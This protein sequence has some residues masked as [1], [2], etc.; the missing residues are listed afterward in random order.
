MAK[1]LT[2]FAKL[3]Y[4]CDIYHFLWE[5]TFMGYMQLQENTDRSTKTE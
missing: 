2:D 1:L 3:S 4:E 5:T